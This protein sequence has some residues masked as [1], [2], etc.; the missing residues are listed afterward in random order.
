V[1]KNGP[2]KIWRLDSTSDRK[3]PPMMVEGFTTVE[4]AREIWEKL[5]YLGF[6]EIYEFKNEPDTT[7]STIGELIEKWKPLLED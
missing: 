3:A 6:E 7:G 5:I 4:Y 2:G 1:F